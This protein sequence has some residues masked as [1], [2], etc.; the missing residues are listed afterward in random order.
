[1]QADLGLF[2]PPEDIAPVIEQLLGSPNTYCY[3]DHPRFH[4]SVQCAPDAFDHHSPWLKA[5]KH[6]DGALE[7]DV[8][9]MPISSPSFASCLRTDDPVYDY[10][11]VEGEPPFTPDLGGEVLDS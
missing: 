8:S 11:L 10:E 6:D 7:G 2:D 1:M 3:F 4:V 5:L 9:Q